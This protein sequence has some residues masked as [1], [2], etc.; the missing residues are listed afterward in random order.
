MLWEG[1]WEGGSCLGTHVRIKD[2][3][4]KK[5]Q[6]KKNTRIKTWLHSKRIEKENK[7]SKMTWKHYVLSITLTKQTNDNCFERETE[8]LLGKYYETWEQKH[9]QW[10]ILDPEI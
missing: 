10:F 9:W 7:K 1:R 3:K 6:T 4:L 8:D 2:K 5:K